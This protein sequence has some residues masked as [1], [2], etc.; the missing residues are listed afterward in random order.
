MSYTKGDTCPDYA[1]PVPLDDLEILTS[2][3]SDPIAF[4]GLK[5]GT[6]GEIGVGKLMSASSTLCPHDLIAGYAS[7][8][9]TDV[10]DR[11]SVIPCL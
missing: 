1:S 4:V 7:T 10:C 8:D 5:S 9:G 6:S 11:L 3:D 2:K